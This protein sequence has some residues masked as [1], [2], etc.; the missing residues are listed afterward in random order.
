MS[1]AEFILSYFP[2]M[3]LPFDIHAIMKY[4]DY[5]I[6]EKKLLIFMSCTSPYSDSFHFSRQSDLQHKLTHICKYTNVDT[7]ANL[8][9]NQ[10]LPSHKHT[11]S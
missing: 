9:K 7:E 8:Q 5:L 3:F 11:F 10:N 1:I 2:K 6:G 4:S